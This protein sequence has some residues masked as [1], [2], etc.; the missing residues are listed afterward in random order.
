MALIGVA[1][2]ARM[3]LLSPSLPADISTRYAAAEMFIDLMKYVACGLRAL[4]D[5]GGGVSIGVCG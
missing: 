4:R 1:I 3:D 2:G 5:A